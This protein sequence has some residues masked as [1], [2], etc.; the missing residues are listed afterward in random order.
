M[1]DEGVG[2]EAR[3]VSS[4]RREPEQLAERA[5]Q[6]IADPDQMGAVSF[7]ELRRNADPAT[8][9]PAAEVPGAKTP[10]AAAP[11][12]D[13]AATAAPVEP[14]AEDIADAL[15][16]RFPALFAGA[17]KP[18]KLRIQADIRERAPGEFSKAALSAFL[19]RHTGRTS[20]LIALTRATHRFDLDGAPADELS[21]EH[22]QA[23]SDELARRRALRETREAQAECERRARAELLRRAGHH[24]AGEFIDPIESAGRIEALEPDS[25]TLREPTESAAPPP[26]HSPESIRFPRRSEE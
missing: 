13:A 24:P 5:S 4:F 12:G 23:A 8:V 9:P 7:P 21:A 17:P 11:A 25:S 14:R 10:V 22:R 6:P 3:R 1:Q 16:Q 2:L 20:Y 26:V 19:R 15:R 18:I